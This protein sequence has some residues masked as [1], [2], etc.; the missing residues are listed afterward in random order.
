MRFASRAAF[1]NM[2]RTRFSHASHPKCLAN[3]VGR[4]EGEDLLTRLK[5]R[6]PSEKWA[7]HWLVKRCKSIEA[8]TTKN[9]KLFARSITAGDG[10]EVAIIRKKMVIVLNYETQKVLILKHFGLA[11]NV[12]RKLHESRCLGPRYAWI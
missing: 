8:S 11:P 9:H 2:L 10:N 5:S 6:I 3:K 4:S 1:Q 7:Q 12:S